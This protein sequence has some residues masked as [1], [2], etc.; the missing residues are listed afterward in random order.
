[1]D[2][3][4]RA[5]VRV[6]RQ[7][8]GGCVK[9]RDLLLHHED[10]LVGPKPE[11]LDPRFGQDLPKVLGGDEVEPRPF[12][13]TKGEADVPRLG[14]EMES[15]IVGVEERSMAVR[16]TRRLMVAKPSAMPRAER[17]GRLHCSV[18]V[19][20][21]DPVEPGAILTEL[22]EGPA[23]G[24]VSCERLA[25]GVVDEGAVVREER[26]DL[27]RERP[28]EATDDTSSDGAYEGGTGSGE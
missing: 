13:V 4:E 10:G 26:K 11:L 25:N 23:S 22:H 20:P 6:E 18:G 2:P 15:R 14:V 21:A 8:G 3:V 24:E 7:D 12:A 19:G 16:R 5:F 17:E 27:G 28:G 9:F 1:V